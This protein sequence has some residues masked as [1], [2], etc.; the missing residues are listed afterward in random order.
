[1]TNTHFR[2]DHAEIV[3]NNAYGYETEK[4]GPF[5]LSNTNF[6]TAGATSLHTTVEDL[7]LWDENFYHPRVGGASFLEQMLQRGKT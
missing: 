2:D 5:R 4:G 1:M 3:K 6:D 7:A